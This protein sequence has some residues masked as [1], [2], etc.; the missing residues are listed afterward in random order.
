MTADPRFSHYPRYNEL[1]YAC[2]HAPVACGDFKTEPEDFR[3]EEVLGFTLSG[4]GEH[5]WLWV[6]ARDMNTEFLVRQLAMAFELEKKAV[7]YSGKKDRRAVTRQWFSL[8]MPGRFASES[9]ISLPDNLHPDLNILKAQLHHKKLRR[10]THKQNRF[11]VRIRHFQG[12]HGHF[13]SQVARI[14]S[15]GFP[16][17]FG[18]Q[19]FGHHE[20][21]IVEACSA[22]TSARR[23]KR[24][25]RDR[26]FSSLRAW[27]FNHQLSLRV[28]SQTWSTYLA[29]DTLQL[30]GSQ[31]LFQPDHWD[32]ELQ[33]RL[34]QGDIHIAGVLPGKGERRLPLPEGDY[35]PAPPLQ[36]YLVKQRV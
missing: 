21:N 6:E 29:G 14:S 8:H 10:G 3:V 1:A 11:E 16:N 18:F 13:G 35:V 2:G 4:A 24:D 28:S 19:R 32:E 22:I 5:L 27:D 30:N 33:A 15:A 12:D 17:Y 25:V 36:E 7:S 31:S 26:V 23:L 34:D 20:N 9:A